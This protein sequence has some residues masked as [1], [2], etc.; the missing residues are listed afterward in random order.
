MI[1]Y[2]PIDSGAPWTD[3]D[4]ADLVS[5]DWQLN[6]ARFG[7]VGDNRQ[8]EVSFPYSHSL[9]VRM[10]DEFPLST[11]SKPTEWAGLIPHHFAYRVKGDAFLEAQSEAWRS[12]EQSPKH[13]RF[14]TGAG[15]LDV[16]TS[17]E[18]HFRLVDC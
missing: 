4:H 9:I 11:E 12:L 15:C 7:I 13:Y 1:E 2:I 16:L 3:A 17:G 8:F 18:P 14:M 5:F 6:V 10:L